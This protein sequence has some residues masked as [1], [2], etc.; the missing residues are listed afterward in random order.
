M[1]Y[2]FTK[3]E[4]DQVKIEVKYEEGL[5]SMEDHDIVVKEE[6]LKEE[7]VEEVIEQPGLG[8][9]GVLEIIDQIDGAEAISAI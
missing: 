5:Q 7:L 8:E 2:T 1:L 4:D 6:I 3:E 9:E